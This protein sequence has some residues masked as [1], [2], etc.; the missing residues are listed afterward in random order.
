MQQSNESDLEDVL[1]EPYSNEDETPKVNLEMKEVHCNM[2]RTVCKTMS[3]S[4]NN[5]GSNSKSSA[6]SDQEEGHDA[7]IGNNDKGSSFA[8]V[9]GDK[10]GH[11]VPTQELAKTSL[12]TMEATPSQDQVHTPNGSEGL[13]PVEQ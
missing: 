2:G 13:A 3:S 1:N 7:T 11:A 9:G 8:D 10:S 4:S 5:G 12:Q 6:A